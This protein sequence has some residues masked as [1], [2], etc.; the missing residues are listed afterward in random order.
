MAPAPAD[1]YYCRGG[2]IA[3]EIQYC[4]DTQAPSMERRRR[5]QAYG[6]KIDSEFERVMRKLYSRACRTSNF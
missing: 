1:D 5:R 2:V 4:R 6:V 3:G